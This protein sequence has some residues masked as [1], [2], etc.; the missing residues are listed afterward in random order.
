MRI[1]DQITG[2]L[3]VLIVFALLLGLLTCPLILF[4]RGSNG[5]TAASQE[6]D[7]GYKIIVK[8]IP[9]D[10]SLYMFDAIL[11]LTFDPLIDCTYSCELYRDGSLLSRKTYG[12]DSYYSKNISMEWLSKPDEKNTVKGRITFEG[13]TTIEFTWSPD[14]ASWE[15]V[16]N[17]KAA[18]QGDARAQYNLGQKYRKGEGVPEDDEEAVKWYRKAA[19]QG[20]AEAWCILGVAYAQGKGVPED[21]EEAVKWYRKAAE[22]GDVRAQCNLGAMYGEGEGVPEDDEEAVKWYRKAAEQ[23]DARAQYNLGQK[24]R[25]GEGVPEDYE[26]AVK[27]YRKAAEQENA[28]AQSN[29]GYMYVNREGVPEN[30]V[31]AYKWFLLA[32]EQG[33][34]SAKVNKEICRKRMSSKQITEALQRAA[35][36]RSRKSSI[37]AE[38]E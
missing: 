18:E 29:L 22:H 10:A 12:W 25:K 11:G 28:K 35:S 9:N 6:N 38:S 27:W 32:A 19:E 14:L 20:L 4:L 24:Y 17:R 7:N 15:N 23:G 33:D 2:V 21:D 36:F 31:E 37:G 34:S 1:I 30:Y 26:E 16:G 8:K 5:Y 13:A 3:L